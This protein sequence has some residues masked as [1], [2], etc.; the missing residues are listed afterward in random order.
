M[1]TR[2]RIGAKRR[3]IP[4]NFPETPPGVPNTSSAG[5]SY[6]NVGLVL[7]LREVESMV[8]SFN[9]DEISCPEAAEW[10]L[11]T[12]KTCLRYHMTDDQ[13]MIIAGM[14]LKGAAKSWFEAMKNELT[15]WN[16]LKEQL[17]IYFPKVVN[18]PQ[19]NRQL[20]RK[21][22][23]EETAEMYVYEKLRLAR[24][25]GTADAALMQYVIEG[26]PCSYQRDILKSKDIRTIPQLAEAIGKLE[27][28]EKPSRKQTI[29][30][31]TNNVTT[32]KHYRGERSR[33]RDGDD[34]R[35]DSEH[36]GYDDR[37]RQRW[38]KSPERRSGFSKGYKF[39]HIE[40]HQYQD[41]KEVSTK[42]ETGSSTASHSAK[43]SGRTFKRLC[44]LCR[45]DEHLAAQ[46]PKNKGSGSIDER[47][48]QS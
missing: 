9:P 13:M 36:C 44:Y 33:S 1:G 37:R 35:S 26:I 17:K 20:E 10:L 34:A 12:E 32:E 16:D 45:S 30:E 18:I 21:K 5:P 31:K 4:E 6:G 43:V 11:S 24:R 41:G 29:T 22:K 8:T 38:N 25:A 42:K 23:P 27:G 39:D 19:I 14:R 47:N 7:G 40:D 28:P 3:I 15:T 2:N 48:R 46:C